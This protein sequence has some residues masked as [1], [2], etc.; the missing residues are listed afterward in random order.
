[1][2]QGKSLESALV[3]LFLSNSDQSP[4]VYHSIQRAIVYTAIQSCHYDGG[5]V[6]RAAL[7]IDMNIPLLILSMSESGVG[8][9]T[10]S[11][12]LHQAGLSR[13]TIDEAFEMAGVE[14]QTPSPGYAYILPPPFEVFGGGGS[15]GNGGGL[16]QA[17]PFTP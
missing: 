8:L 6:V 13:A 16:G 1:M 17:S 4:Q 11:D 5:D 12:A 9:E 15:S 10:L 7:R 2:N 3:D 14:G